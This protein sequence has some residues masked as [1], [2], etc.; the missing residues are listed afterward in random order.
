MSCS[1]KSFLIKKSL[2][3]DCL[4]SPSSHVTMD[5]NPENLSNGV[6]WTEEEHRII[7][8]G[9]EKLGKGEWRGIS[10]NIVTT[11]MPKQVASHAQKYFLRKNSLNKRRRPTSLFDVGSEKFSNQMV[12]SRPPEPFNYCGFLLKKT[13]VVPIIL[14]ARNPIK[15]NFEDLELPLRFKESCTQIL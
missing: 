6:P 12:H 15:G 10:R 11:I 5:E 2:S 3:M 13:N 1:S 4:S 8:I 14:D 7:L 9:L